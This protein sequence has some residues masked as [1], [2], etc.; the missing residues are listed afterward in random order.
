[1]KDFIQELWI[2]LRVTLALA[3]LLCGIY[4]LLVWIVG[5]GLFPAE[6]NGSLLV[7]RGTLVGSILLSQGFTDPK[8]FHPRPSAAGQGYDA[9]G[10]G[11]S[12]LGPT[13]KKLVDEVRQRVVDYRI[14]NGLGPDAI[15]PADA[16]TASASGLDPHISVK[17][18]LLQA[19]RVAKERS[20]TV[21]VI[22]K[23]ID[24]H[25]E[26]RTFGILGEPR[27][28]VLMLNLDLDG[29]L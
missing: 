17:N 22:M 26:N 25:T 10:S 12:N 19:R 2:S 16:V 5:Q 8:Y 29:K 27:V 3:I 20:L 4:P 7:H 28:N 18:G 23:K 24:A 9:A 11:G 13:S 6:S 1:M 15:V 14:E 21:E